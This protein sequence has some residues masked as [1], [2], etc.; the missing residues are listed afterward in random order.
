MLKNPIYLVGGARPNFMKV[1]PLI[2]ELEKNK[3]PYKLIHTGQHY[4]YNMSKVFFDD[5]GIPEPDFH[6]GVGSGTHAEQTAQ[7]MVEFE[8]IVNQGNPALVIVV[9]DVNSTIACALVAKKLFVKVAHIEAGLRSF[10]M[11]MP[12]EINRILT[13]RISDY[14][15]TTERSGMENLKTEGVPLE[16]IFFVGNIMIDTL[17]MN[18]AKAEKTEYFRNLGLKKG[19]YALLTLHRPSNVDD[20]EHLLEILKIINYLKEKIKIFFPA[21]PR[22]VK[23][24]K[25]FGIYNR[26]DKDQNIAITEPVGYLEFLN[27]MSNSRI[28]LTDSGGIQEEASVLNIPV[29]TLRENTERPITINQGTNVLVGRDFKKAKKYIDKILTD[30]IKKK[31]QIKYWDGHTAE[32]IVEILINEFSIR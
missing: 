31:T 29:L 24:L 26:L 11:R 7:I 32:R 3:I 8:K 17:F 1:A 13:D 6:L 18:L 22:T 14:L 25:D 15:F 4:D 21:H 5:L 10:D 16:K 27:L 9:G 19:S 12:E 2:K 23:N 28:I 30:K 20:K